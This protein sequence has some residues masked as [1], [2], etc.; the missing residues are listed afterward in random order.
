[1]GVMLDENLINLSR[2]RPREDALTHDQLVAINLFWRRGVKVT[3]IAKVFHASKNTLYYRALTGTA[4]S[5]QSA[6]YAG[7][8]QEINA[9]VDKLGHEKA[10]DQYVTDDMVTAIHAALREDI[11]RRDSAA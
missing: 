6:L 7:Q 1:M 3:I 2:R 9:L 8:A 11:E 10:W 4:D 5:S